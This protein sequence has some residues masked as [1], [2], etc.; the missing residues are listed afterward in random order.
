VNV[1]LNVAPIGMRPESQLLSV[2]AMRAATVEELALEPCLQQLVSEFAESTG[3]RVHLKILL[4]DSTPL[5]PELS[6]A[7]YR[8]VQEELT[9][10]HRHARATTVKVRLESSTERVVLEIRDDGIGSAVASNGHEQ[11]SGAY[12]LVGLR[13]RVA[14][15]EGQMVFGRSPRGGSCLT[16]VLPIH[17]SASVRRRSP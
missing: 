6:Q 2:A 1:W 7:L 13:E 4:P 16:I 11:H 8:A 9:N 14:L 5:A 3:L 17:S 15:L 10:V 12:G